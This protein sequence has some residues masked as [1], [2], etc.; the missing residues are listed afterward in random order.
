[1]NS[2]S[3]ESFRIYEFIYGVIRIM[4]LKF[5]LSVIDRKFSCGA[6]NERH[7]YFAR[8]V[9]SVLSTTLTHGTF[10]TTLTTTA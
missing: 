9:N 10:L 2:L 1:L 4:Y 7:A 6:I 3:K 8:K 5:V